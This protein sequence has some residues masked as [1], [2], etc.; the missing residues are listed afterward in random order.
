M[1]PR[2]SHRCRSSIDTNK[3][4]ANINKIAQQRNDQVHVQPGDQVHIKCRKQYTDYRR[5]QGDQRGAAGA[6]SHH[7]WIDPSACSVALR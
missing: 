2:L 5:E 1:Q 7:Q 3:S 6:L 4:A